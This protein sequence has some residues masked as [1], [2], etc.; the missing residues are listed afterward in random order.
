L[1]E[2][3][4]PP[5]P[6]LECGQRRS[7]PQR[8]QGVYLARATVLHDH[9]RR[10]EHQ[11]GQRMG[12][13]SVRKPEPP[14][15]HGRRRQRQERHATHRPWSDALRL[16]SGEQDDQPVLQRRLVQVRLTEQ[17]R[18]DEVA[19]VD[20]LLRDQR[21]ARLFPLEREAPRAR[22]VDPAQKPAERRR[23]GLEQPTIPAH[24]GPEL[25]AKDALPTR[26]C[27]RAFGARSGARRIPEKMKVALILSRWD[28]ERRRRA[29]PSTP[30]TT[31][32]R[33]P[34]APAGA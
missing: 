33:R 9:R 1:Q 31:V 34:V 18:H 28:T 19:G 17:T 25:I 23:L 21:A 24:E 4:L 29:C 7:H 16:A 22:E 6:G 10:Q 2:R 5:T 15:E 30:S 12:R 8:E 20:H 3:P 32:S 13:R 26:S 11:R 14:Q 27:C